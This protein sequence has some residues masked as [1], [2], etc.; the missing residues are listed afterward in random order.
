MPFTAPRLR[1]R[2]SNTL[3][4][5]VDVAGPLGITHMMALS[6]TTTNTLLRLCRIPHGPTLTFRLETYS[7]ARQVRAAQRNPV[8]IAT[9][10][11]HPPLVVL[12]GFNTAGSSE[13]AA[14]TAGVSLADAL[15]MTTTML[16]NTFPQIQPATVKVSSCKRVV[17]FH[18]DAA[19]GL[20]EFRHFYVRTVSVGMS[21]AV[22]KV[23]GSQSSAK[24]LPDLGKLGDVS[25]F[26]LSGGRTGT[27]SDSEG[28]PDEASRVIMPAV[29]A[30][31]AAA[32]AGAGSGSGGRSGGQQSSIRLSEIGPRLTLRL[33][34]IEQELARGEVLYH[35][36]ESRTVAQ[37]AEL[38]KG[39]AERERQKEARKA[40]QAEN[41][42][43]KEAERAAKK[44]AKDERRAARQEAAKQAAAEGRLADDEGAIAEA[45]DEEDG[46]EE[47]A[48]E[49]EEE[50]G[51]DAEELDDDEDDDAGSFHDDGE[52]DDAEAG[53]AAAAG[54]AANDSDDEEGDDTADEADESA[55]EEEEDE[56]EEAAG[57]SEEELEA[58]AEA[59]VGAGS[60]GARAA[61]AGAPAP[62][63]RG[64]P[65]S[66]AGDK[67]ARGGA[68]RGG[69][70][71]G[72]ARATSAHS[73]GSGHDRRSSSPGVGDKRRMPGGG[74]GGGG[75]RGASRG[76]GGGAG[77]GRGASHA[78]KPR[79]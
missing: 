74:R 46:E 73:A 32:A 52:D 8:D 6:Q 43:R 57:D 68:S 36:F 28:E 5:F 1:E 66:A 29:G 42:A 27:A 9:A 44:A 70:G 59:D 35:A 31:A 20:I 2:R 15:K 67:A 56:G 77:R 25:E 19:S 61:G 21:R 11:E 3:R 16:Q 7:L 34:K 37:A 71:R 58:E 33:V 45:S 40:V 65:Q 55:E 24:H 75:S 18:Y 63:A 17:L 30:A 72:A 54:A 26:V 53:E 4:D 39:A 14:G 79:R 41:V 23:A 49:V 13:K 51:G 69:R 47:E 78:K 62:Q 48:D 22:Q 10:F 64:R 60:S 12:H 76:R 50:E 38:R